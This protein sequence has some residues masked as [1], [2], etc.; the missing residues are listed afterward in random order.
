MNPTTTLQTLVHY[1]EVLMT[2][3]MIIILI[4]TA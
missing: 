1:V 2:G 3:V 4:L